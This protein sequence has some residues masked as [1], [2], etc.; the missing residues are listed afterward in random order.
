MRKSMQ[1][2][3]NTMPPITRGLTN[4]D[5]HPLSPARDLTPSLTR[6]LP[7]TLHRITQALRTTIRIH[8]TD[9]N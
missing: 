6:Q 8:L 3:N 1:P 5:T 4:V 2:I 7:P 9:C